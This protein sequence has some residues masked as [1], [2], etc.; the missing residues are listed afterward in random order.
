MRAH[1]L[2]E[3]APCD[4]ADKA[5]RPDEAK[6]KYTNLFLKHKLTLARTC[7]AGIWTRAR[8][9]KRLREKGAEQSGT[10]KGLCK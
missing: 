4:E 3:K 5:S 7:T 8:A 10:F 1:S 9:A 2:R 6:A